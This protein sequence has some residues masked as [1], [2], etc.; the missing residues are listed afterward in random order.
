MFM[1]LLGLGLVALSAYLW[2]TRGFFSSLIHLLCVIAAGAIAFGVWEPVSYLLLSVAPERGFGSFLSDVAWAVGLGLP[3]AIALTL[4]RL[5]VDSL[6]PANA[7]CSNVADYVGG[8]I[9]GALSGVI[10]GGILVLSLGFLRL[11][12]DAGGYQ[13][14]NYSSGSARGSLERTANKLIPWVDQLTAKA[15]STMSETTL[16]T[17]T[18]LARWHPDF[19]ALPSTMRITYEGKSRTTLKKEAISFL[20]WYT[21][22]DTQRGEKLSDLLTDSWAERPQEI[23][24][25]KGEKPLSGYLAGFITKLGPKAKEKTGQVVIGAGQ[26]RLACE[27]SEGDESIAL[28]PI[29]VVT[30]VDDPTRIAYARFRFDSDN[31]FVASVGGSAEATFGFEFAIP[32]GFKPVALYV[33][34]VR[35]DLEGTT[36]GAAFPSP[37]DRDQAITGGVMPGM[38]GVGPIIDPNTGQPVP[39]PPGGTTFREQAVTVQNGLG[40]GLTIQKG[41]EG[42]SLTVAEEGKSWAIVDGEAKFDPQRVGRVV[43]RKLQINKFSL[44]DDTVLVKVVISPA[45]RTDEFTKALDSAEKNKPPSL[46]DNNGTRYDA[47]GFIYRDLSLVHIR[48]TKGNPLRGLGESGVPTVSRNTPERSLTLLFVVSR[49]VEIS[50][51]RVGDKLIETYAPTIKTIQR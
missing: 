45:Q 33:K 46:I 28:H 29:A 24:D 10:C 5:A 30:N 50:E 38:G 36:A 27:N 6:L 14:V 16:R 34:G 40:F 15:Y 25:L 47:V 35:L 26:V 19:A 21:V 44:T 41:T 11:G 9:C 2:L 7:Q 23:A 20:G 13:L 3:F 42:A 32:T 8:G 37:D 4:L 49:G 17:G 12:P 51:F 43:D 48:F 31:F 18:P 1:L 39:P 22:G